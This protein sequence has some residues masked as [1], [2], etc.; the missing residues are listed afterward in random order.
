[1]GERGRGQTNERVGGF[2]FKQARPRDR[3]TERQG[4]WEVR[5]RTDDPG[6]TPSPS[7]DPSEL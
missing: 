4:G 3:D 1:M 6:N 7:S 2:R 5:L